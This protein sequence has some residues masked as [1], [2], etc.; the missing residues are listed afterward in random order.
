MIRQSVEAALLRLWFDATPPWPLRLAGRLLGPLSRLTARVATRKRAQIAALAPPPV[1]LVVV[2]NLLVGGVGKTPLV[3]A[4]VQALAARGWRPG[5]LASGHGARRLD[6]RLVGADDDPAEHG[7]EAVLLARLAGRPLAAGRQRADALACLLA[8][9]P[10][11]DIVVSDDGLQHAALPRS[12]ELAVFDARGAGNGRLL[13]AGPLR[14][15]LAHLQQM[16]ALLVNGPATPPAAGPRLFR[17]EVVPGDFARVAR[18]ARVARGTGQPAALIAESLSPEAFRCL[19]AT[20]RPFPTAPDTPNAQDLPGAIAAV[21]GIGAPQRFF[22]T[23]TALGLPPGQRLTPGD[24][25]PL[26]AATLAALDARFI[27][28]TAKDAVKCEAW[29]D[30]RCWALHASARLDPAFVDWLDD[31]LREGT[32][33][34]TPARHPG[35]PDLQG[36]AEAGTPRQG[37]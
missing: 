11:I 6:A 7:D 8:A 31:S 30:D 18:V 12:V 33:G 37:R 4:I 23:L 34:S 21:A 24:H 2:G 15:P 13:P 28:M 1:P 19:V 22:D 32:R 35:L 5:L 17:F 14:E 20:A 16:D 26:D 36:P 3:V 27:V 9:H 29:A 25:R 10:E